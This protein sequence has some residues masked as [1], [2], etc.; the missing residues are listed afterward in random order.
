VT[1]KSELSFVSEAQEIS[2]GNQQYLQSQQSAGGKYLLDP[3]LAA[4]VSEVGRK[5]VK[6][7][8]RP[9][10]PF[11]FVVIND[12]VPNAWALPG[13]KLA[14]NRGLLTELKSEAGTGGGARPRDRARRRA[15]RR[16]FGGAGHAA[17]GRRGDHFRARRRQRMP[18]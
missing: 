16:A 18:A 9:N 13:G 3:A 6:V 4:Y 8:D 10:L 17:V 15:P 11:E 12:S 1:R 5:L 2:I 7:S 14:I